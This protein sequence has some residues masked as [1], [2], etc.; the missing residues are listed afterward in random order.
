VR[1]LKNSEPDCPVCHRTV[2]GAPE[3]YKCEPAT[4]GKMEAR[5][6]IIHWTVRCASGLLGEP[7]EQRLPAPTADSA[8]CYST[9]QCRD[10]VRSAEVRGH[11]TVRSGTGLSGTA[12]RQ[13]APTVNYSEP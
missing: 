1:L 11:R 10:R 4:L 7:A 8:K 5:S 6:A 13:I 3:P 2:F 12:R 9:Q